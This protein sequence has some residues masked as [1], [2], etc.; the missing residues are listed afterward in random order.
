MAVIRT[1]L[2][3]EFLGDREFKIVFAMVNERTRFYIADRYGPLTNFHRTGCLIELRDE[4]EYWPM[5]YDFIDRAIR[6][7]VIQ[8][9]MMLV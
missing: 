3:K 4:Y 5:I 7:P 2:A 6:D 8:M 9:L 1:V